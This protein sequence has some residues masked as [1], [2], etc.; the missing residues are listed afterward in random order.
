MAIQRTHQQLRA[1][2][3]CQEVELWVTL[4]VAGFAVGFFAALTAFGVYSWHSATLS[5]V[6]Y[7]TFTIGGG[8]GAFSA[9]VTVIAVSIL[10]GEHY[11]RKEEYYQKIDSE[12]K[13]LPADTQALEQEL[14][15]LKLQ[16]AEDTKAH[17]L[18]VGKL[19]LQLEIKDEIAKLAFEARK[20]EIEKGLEELKQA[21][22][23][24]QSKEHQLETKLQEVEEQKKRLESI[25]K[26]RQEKVNVLQQMIEERK[27]SREPKPKVT[28]DDS[29][30]F[31]EAIEKLDVRLRR[32][33]CTL[34]NENQVQV[35]EIE[36]MHYILMRKGSEYTQEAVS[37]ENLGDRIVFY[38][39]Q[40]G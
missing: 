3:K 24:Y 26:E 11:C 28:D 12:V 29:D 23:Q 17:K 8:A 9:I 31:L 20:K 7:L 6:W 22:A 25:E 39:S 38:A 35:V 4:A 5:D 1:E 40:T 14:S 34:V 19:K 33:A 2:E 32:Y 13:E 27:A 37:R 21:K 15:Q 18:E 36:G 16:H 30:K 10:L